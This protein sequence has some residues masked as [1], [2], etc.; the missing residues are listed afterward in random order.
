MLG[1]ADHAQVVSL[2]KSIAVSTVTHIHSN[3]VNEL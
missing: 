3:I 1:V 2:F